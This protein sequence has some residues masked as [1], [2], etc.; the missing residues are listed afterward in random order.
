MTLSAETIKLLRAEHER[1]TRQRDEIVQ[2]INAI[3]G[4][5]Q[6]YPDGPARASTPP[7]ARKRGSRG[8]RAPTWDVEKGRKLWDRGAS[9]DDIAEA[10]DKPVA[11]VKTYARNHWPKR[12]KHSRDPMAGRRSISPTACPSCERT[13]RYNPCEHCHVQLPTALR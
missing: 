5:L 9:L 1:L 4:V 13:T 6:H 12:P 3:E 2:V 7:R 8:G 10:V 11:A